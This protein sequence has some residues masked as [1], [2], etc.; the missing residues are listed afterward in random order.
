MSNYSVFNEDEDDIFLGSP[1]S[2]F[3]DVLRNASSSIVQDEVDKIMEK[4][5]ICEHILSKEK[6]FDIDKDLEKYKIENTEEI[7]N[8]KKGLY[9]EYTGEIIQR[10]DS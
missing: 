7:E 6:N 4:L 8:M 10:L 2:K 3:C 9:L 1:K 5:A